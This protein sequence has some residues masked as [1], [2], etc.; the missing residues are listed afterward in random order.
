MA[1]QI[2]ATRLSPADRPPH[3]DLLPAC[4]EK[5]G[6]SFVRMILP[7]NPQL[8]AIR[9]FAIRRSPAHINAWMPVCARPR[10]NA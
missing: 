4:G 10:I 6:A 2:L 5:E 1:L 9:Y 8:V 7:L 3:P